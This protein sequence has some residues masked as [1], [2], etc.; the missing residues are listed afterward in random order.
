MNIIYISNSIIPSRNANSI[1]VMKM[2][3]AFA[4]NG[5]NITLYSKK[6]NSN[7]VEYNYYGVKDIFEICRFSVFPIKKVDSLI[8]ALQIKA[9]MRKNPIPDLFYGRNILGLLCASSFNKPIIYEAHA[10]PN[11]YIRKLLEEYLFNN[12]NFKSLVVIS[13]ALKEAYLRL[14]PFLKNKNI[15][16][17]ADGADIPL[18]SNRE[19]IYLIGNEG[20]VKIGY[21]GHLYPGRGIDLII[22]LAEGLDSHEFHLIGGTEEDIRLWQE[23]TKNIKNIFFYG[24]I[25]NGDL[26]NYYHEMDILLAPYEKKVSVAGGAGDTSKWMSPLKIFEYMSYKKPMIVSDMP[27]LREVLKNE[28]NCI[29]SDPEDIESWKRAIELLINNSNIC[30]YISENAYKD[31]INNYTWTKRAE[32]VLDQL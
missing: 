14:W 27:V 30:E 32:N 20:K 2:C 9:H 10:I 25:S 5:N 15:I 26:F 13:Q 8:Y 6:E 21:V 12:K 29:L 23:K 1:H 24:Y 22:N 31:F 28:H 4:K 16:V 17:A 3:Y 11:T 19:Q 7:D 18:D